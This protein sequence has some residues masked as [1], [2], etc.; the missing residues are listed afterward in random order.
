M[1]G[2]IL[3]ADDSKAILR[4]LEKH[5]K[6]NDYDVQTA[7]DGVAA[8]EL[9]KSV[10]PDVV[11]L[12]IR[13]PKKDGIEVLDEIHKIDQQ[14]PVIMITAIEDMHTV[15][16]TIQRGAYEYENKPIDIDKLDVIINRAMEAKAL[17]DQVSTIVDQSREEFKINNIIGK[18]EKM[19]DIFKTIGRVSSSRT[20]VLITGESGTGKELV[21]KAIHYNSPFASSPFVAVNCTALTETLL[22]SEIFGHVKGAFTGAVSDKKGKFEA[23]SDGSIFLDE[24]GEMSPSL[25]VKILRVLQEREFER[26]GSNTT[27]K[28]K[29][30]VIAA[31]NTHLDVNVGS[32][33]FREDL[34]YRLKVVEILMPPLRE[35]KKDIPLLTDYLLEKGARELHRD[36]PIVPDGVKKRLMEY[37]WPGNI[38]E[39]ENMLTRAMVL[40][41]GD[42]LSDDLFHFQAPPGKM[43][44]SENDA[45]LAK[46]SLQEIEKIHIERVLNGQSWNKRKAIQI[47]KITRP[48]LDKKIR[49]YG[50]KK[51]V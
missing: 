16:K 33:K 49:E 41:K 32:G 17:K 26:V 19:R 11:L 35:R 3:I 44:A 18:S 23:A 43:G 28:C 40:G 29:A 15:V 14:V 42:V 20:T 5:F 37:K 7:L 22:E 34:Y 48:T 31:T 24:I 2:T 21:A 39:L 25:Q 46:L 9:F 8:I 36:I 1:K 10:K 27:L 38:R 12:D 50:I 13:M 30:R 51:K 4:T 47:L 45:D 6:E